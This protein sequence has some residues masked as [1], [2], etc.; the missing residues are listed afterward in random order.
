MRVA[1]HAP[2]RADD[3]QDIVPARQGRL[4]HEP[5]ADESAGADDRYAAHRRRFQWRSRACACSA[6]LSQGRSRGVARR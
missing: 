4:L 3:R 5:G 1:G 6:A 2:E